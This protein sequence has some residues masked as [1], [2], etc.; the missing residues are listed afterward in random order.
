MRTFCTLMF[1]RGGK[2]SA[3]EN[4][5]ISATSRQPEIQTKFCIPF[6]EETR[7]I[8]YNNMWTNLATP[9]GRRHVHGQ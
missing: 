8:G 6:L 7:L 1:D 5:P 9:L 3:W 4:G 2:N